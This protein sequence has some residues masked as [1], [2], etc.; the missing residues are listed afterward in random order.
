MKSL[1][2]LKEIDGVKVLFVLLIPTKIFPGME[3]KT[4][5]K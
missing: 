3:Q 5:K 2:F 4:V 1:L